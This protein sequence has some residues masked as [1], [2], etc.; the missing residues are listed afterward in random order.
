ML[1]R[2]AEID[3]SVVR[4][5]WRAGRTGVALTTGLICFHYTPPKRLRF[6]FSLSFPSIPPS[7]LLSLS[8][9]LLLF[10]SSSLSLISPGSICVSVTG[11]RQMLLTKNKDSHSSPST[12]S[13]HFALTVCGRVRT[14]R[15]VHVW[16]DIHKPLLSTE[17]QRG[18]GQQ[19]WLP[20]EPLAVNGTK[21][22]TLRVFPP[23]L[24]PH[25]T[26]LF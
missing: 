14:C 10:I 25:A 17:V 8:V 26:L 23:C 20:P 3:I 12:A 1:S 4:K 24:L 11:A 21:R 18:C 9:S 15:C 7:I 16:A 2:V 5:R 22:G 13:S 19:K 6:V